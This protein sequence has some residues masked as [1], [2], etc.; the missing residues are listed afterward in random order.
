MQV[1]TKRFLPCPRCIGGQMMRE[2]DKGIQWVCLQCGYIEYKYKV[3]FGGRL[4]LVNDQSTKV[5]NATAC[6]N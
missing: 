2:E 6:E 3:G 5:K 4:K 1:Q